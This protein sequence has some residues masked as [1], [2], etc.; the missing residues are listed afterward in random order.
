MGRRR[1]KNKQKRN[2]SAQSQ[3]T[4]SSM[5]KKTKDQPE[6]EENWENEFVDR[7]IHPQSSHFAQEGTAK[8]CFSQTSKTHADD[9]NQESET[10]FAAAAMHYRESFNFKEQEMTDKD[11][12]KVKEDTQETNHE[13]VNSDELSL[14]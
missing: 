13:R 3:A 7:T 1:G 12:I 6:G 10:L 4:A 5:K 9:N 14:Q 11:S 8:T 2:A